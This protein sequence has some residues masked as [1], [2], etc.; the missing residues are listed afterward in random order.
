MRLRL[1]M[2]VFGAALLT[3]AASGSAPAPPESPITL[4][5]SD[6]LIR[7]TP[8]Y[9]G[10]LVK[11]DGKAPPIYDVVL[12]LTSPREDLVC[13]RKGKVGPFWL[14][15]GQVRFG[16]VPWM[17]KIKS[18][19]PVDDILTASEQVKY[20]LGR[21]GLKASMEVKGGLDS[22]LYLDELIL[23]RERNRL[24]S[25]HEG[26]VEREGNLYSTSFFWPPDGPPGRYRVEAYA[27]DD[28]KVVGSAEV[29]VEVRAVGLESWIRGL[30][31]NHGILYGLFAVGLALGA[32]LAVS[33]LFGG[34]RRSQ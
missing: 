2:I 34:G 4:H 31:S 14:S 24:F 18:T 15:V 27:V 6:Q 28:G 3:L 25:F 26:Q 11:V 33:F 16:D 29:W 17:F 9:Q 23:I 20:R 19:T 10:E 30:A 7:I 32:G 13:S 8:R 1:P 5:V 22:G 12:K 21:E